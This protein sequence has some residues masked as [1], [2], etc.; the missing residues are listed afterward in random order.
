[1]AFSISYERTNLLSRGLGLEHLQELLL[2]LVRPILRTGASLAYARHWRE[3][4]DNFTYELLRLI[5][6]EKEDKS[7]EKEDK[8]RG[9]PVIG[10]L[11]NHSAWPQYLSVKPET[12]A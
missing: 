8:S 4:E 12:E 10:Y 6:A 9:G 2:R 11:Y 7:P 3:S 5:N 1:I